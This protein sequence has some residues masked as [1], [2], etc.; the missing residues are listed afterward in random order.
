MKLPDYLLKA[1]NPKDAET[2]DE[3]KIQLP[4]NLLDQITEITR[5]F[6][7]ES[8]L[9][10]GILA[11]SRTTRGIVDSS[12]PII[13]TVN[14]LYR[15]DNLSQN[16]IEEIRFELKDRQDVIAS[17]VLVKKDHQFVLVH[18]VIDR[19]LRRQGVGTKLLTACE[20]YVEEVAKEEKKDQVLA[21]NACQIDVIKWLDKL[22]YQPASDR[23]IGELSKLINA[24]EDEVF[25]DYNQAVYFGDEYA[26]NDPARAFKVKLQK[27]IQYPHEL[28]DIR[29][30]CAETQYSATASPNGR[31]GGI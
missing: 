4:S 10:S 8:K 2:S 31:S 19:A 3:N 24:K 12:P 1:A 28:D 26:I 15:Q 17:M 30:I 20:K 9:P 16:Q 27:K 11:N 13:F 7:S 23:D 5:F 21:V 14:K 18:R 25:L 6:Y 29:A 22:G